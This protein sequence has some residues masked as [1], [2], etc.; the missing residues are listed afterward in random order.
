M[1]KE[2]DLLCDIKLSQMKQIGHIHWT[3]QWDSYCSVGNHVG[4]T[5]QWNTWI[6]SSH[7]IR[8]YF[9]ISMEFIQLRILDPLI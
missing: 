8:S 7:G 9:L 5:D 2:S 3:H 6:A 1:D 4:S